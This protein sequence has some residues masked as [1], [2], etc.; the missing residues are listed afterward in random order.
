MALFRAGL[1]GCRVVPPRTIS[2]R[3][4]EAEEWGIKPLDHVYDGDRSGRSQLFR[5]YN[6][7]P[8]IAIDSGV[9]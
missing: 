7:S 3:A 5:L 1:G 4:E 9:E 8:P 2:V 6:H